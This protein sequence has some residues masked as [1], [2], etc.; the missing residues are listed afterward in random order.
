MTRTMR[1]CPTAWSHADGAVE[2]QNSASVLQIEEKADA[3]DGKAIVDYE[4]DVHYKL[5]G[6]DPNGEPFGWEEVE[7]RVYKNEALSH[8]GTYK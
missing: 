3:K 2:Q 8:L 1:R 4:L 6:P 5:E 7:E